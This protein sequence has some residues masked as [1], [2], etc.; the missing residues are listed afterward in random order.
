MLITCPH[1][2]AAAKLKEIEQILGVYSAP[3]YRLTCTNCAETVVGAPP[4]ASGP[5]VVLLPA[6]HNDTGKS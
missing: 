3:H 6:L 2:G 5:A 1:C 4:D